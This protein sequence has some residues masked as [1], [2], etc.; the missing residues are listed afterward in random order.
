MGCILSYFKNN[1]EMNETFLVTSPRCFVC[2][3]VFPNM[4]DYN[5]HIVHC[6]LLYQKT[7]HSFKN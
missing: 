7:T 5:K 2:D 3:K 1:D 6:N 4:T